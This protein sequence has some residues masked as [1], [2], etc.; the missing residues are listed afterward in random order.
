MRRKWQVNKYFLKQKK[1]KKKK[2]MPPIGGLW[3]GS[4]ASENTVSDSW[5]PQ[6]RSCRQGHLEKTWAAQENA[7]ALCTFSEMAEL[8]VWDFKQLSL[9]SKATY[10]FIVSIL[11]NFP[12]WR[13]LQWTRGTLAKAVDLIFLFFLF[14]VFEERW[15]CRLHGLIPSWKPRQIK[16]EI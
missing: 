12:I 3:K 13:V 2:K 11:W 6:P 5:G 7:Q 4:N 16:G 15:S 9:A 14:K 1:K 10:K 8:D